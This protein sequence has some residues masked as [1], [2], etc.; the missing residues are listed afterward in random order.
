LSIDQKS[1]ILF[2]FSLILLIC[3]VIL[4]NDQIDDTV[5]NIKENNKGRL[6]L[7]SPLKPHKNLNKDIVTLGSVL[8]HD[9]R[10]SKDNSISCESC[11][12]LAEGG[13]D[14]RK[15]PKG[16][17]DQKGPINTLSVIN[18]S[19]NE[20]LMW[21]GRVATLEEQ[22]ELPIHNEKEMASNWEEIIGKLNKDK[23]VVKLFKK[24]FPTRKISSKTIS[25]SLAD[26]QRTLDTRNSR[27]D[28]YLK[29]D[30]SALNDTE[31]K[32]YKL[33]NSLGCMLCH[34]G[35]NIGG[36]RIQK[37]G[38]LNDF[39]KGREI[40]KADLGRFNVTGLEEDRFKFRVPSLRNIEHTAPYFHDG[41]AKTLYEAV[42]TMAWVQLGDRLED[43][44]IK[45]LVAFL[46]TLSSPV[47]DM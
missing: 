30:K 17:H 44:Q 11:H 22:V 45:K 29:G 27:F 8:F 1:I 39:F 36:K 35:S 33:F 43:D 41:S 46:R 13:D 9:K 6:D 21:D 20:S 47:E 40:T 24:A 3:Y 38:K 37:I 28:Q 12:D 7:I 19:F 34:N 14:H 42:D 15:F 25:K 32:G 26:F 10:L 31:K 16:I 23:T 4:S 5:L 18:A 2:G